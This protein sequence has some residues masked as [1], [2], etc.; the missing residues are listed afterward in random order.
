MRRLIH[1][2]R[3]VCL[4]EGF[5]LLEI[6]LALSVLG[7]LMALAIPSYQQ[8]VYRAWRSDAINQLLSAASCQE[9]M[10]VQKG[11]YN[12]KGCT[13]QF[14]T[15]HYRIMY[16][17]ENLDSSER[18]TVIAEA[19]NENAAGNCGRLSLDHSG[20]RGIDGDSAYQRKCW[21]GR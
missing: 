15:E 8:Y 12:A 20:T 7:V 19:K 3:L 9:R 16:L 6:M 4:P 14:Q 2:L 10:F 17:P 11:G 13:D 18:F 5:S 1:Q 21:E